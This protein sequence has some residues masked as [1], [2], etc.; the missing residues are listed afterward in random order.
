[1]NYRMITYILGWILLFEAAFLL[2]PSITA[3]VYLERAG[4]AFLITIGICLL[5]SSLLILKKPQNTDLHSR[6]GFVIVSLSWIFLSLFGALPFIFSGATTSYI[7]AFF[8]TVSGFTTTGASIFGD[9]EILP[10]C[11]LIWRSFTHWVG[12][13]G[14]L[15]FIMAFLPLSGGRNM[16]IMKAES[17]GPSVGK[18][19][20]RVR[21]TA[22]WLYGIYFALTLVMF[23]VFLIGK[24]PV[25]DAICTAF[26]TA[27]TGGF[28]IKNSGMSSYS[29]FLQ[30]TISVFMLLFSINFESYFAL[31]QRKW[32]SIF[33]AEVITFLVI[34]AAATGIITWNLYHNAPVEQALAGDLGN[35]ARHAFFTVSSLISTTGFATI[36]FALWPSIS[37]TVLILLYFIGACAGSTGG[38]VKISRI[39]ILFKGLAREIGNSIHPKRVKKVTVGKKEVESETVRS[40]FVFFACLFA[41]FGASLLLISL[42]G[43][44]FLTNFSAVATTLGNVGPGFSEV[45]PT[46]NFA[47]FSAL[48]KLVLSFDM[49]AGRLELFPMLV[50]FS[51]ATWKKY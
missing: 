46:K 41:L 39:L 20:P 9:V 13:M 48:S 34:V 10:K 12:G 44:D 38:G 50:L 49:L 17:P 28:S 36:D 24:M 35:T 15:V 21:T 7:D 16:H 6:D 22:I 25:F 47:D 1:M 26:G 2:V 32:R 29:P 3:L 33:T 18:L 40:V 4:F 14:V 5:V 23:A 11:V 51:P 31:V 43:K 30:I 37:V 8:E 27:G 45:G 19:V 42:D